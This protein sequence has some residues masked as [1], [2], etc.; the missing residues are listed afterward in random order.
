ML[1]FL[2]LQVSYGQVTDLAVDCINI[3][4]P[5]PNYTAN[6][7]II[8]NALN[9]AN[10][11]WMENSGAGCVSIGGGD[12]PTTGVRVRS[13]TTFRIE[14]DTR[15]LNVVNVTLGQVRRED[16]YKYILYIHICVCVCVCVY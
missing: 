2:L 12:Y 13:G 14:Q 11:N 4:A 6:T 16:M 8:Q 5:S 7:L 10:Q 9:K 1:L 3:R 15:L